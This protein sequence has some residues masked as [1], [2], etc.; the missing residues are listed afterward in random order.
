MVKEIV[1][2]INLV[3]ISHGILVAVLECYIVYQRVLL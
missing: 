3:Y 1:V 2:N